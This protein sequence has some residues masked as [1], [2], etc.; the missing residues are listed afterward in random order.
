[1]GPVLLPRAPLAVT[2]A[3]VIVHFLMGALV[4]GTNEFD[5]ALLGIG[6]IL[7]G[8]LVCA[9]AFGLLSG[10]YPDPTTPVTGWRKQ[11]AVA[12][13]VLALV[14]VA[15]RFTVVRSKLA[16]EREGRLSILTLSSQ[17][18]D[19]DTSL[20]LDRLVIAD[21]A[22]I[23]V[24]HGVS[25]EIRTKELVIQGAGKFD[26]SGDT[27]AVGRAASTSPPPPIKFK[28]L[29]QNELLNQCFSTPGGGQ[30]GGEGGQ[31]GRGA[32]IEI[33]A[34]SLTGDPSKLTVDV[35]GGPGG[36]GGPG[37]PMGTCYGLGGRTV[38]RGTRAPGSNGLQGPV[39]HWQLAIR[40]PQGL[41][42]LEPGR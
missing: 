18:F 34:D 24:L 28:T 3:A 1:M 41:T 6:G 16:Y 12:F 15:W 20:Q 31:G 40:G 27:G 4:G 11:R 9:F 25:L 35:S 22:Q 26:G 42:I 38:D 36:R 21:R 14:G 13:C 32:R 39:G 5:A 17:V 37:G 10:P 7:G 30:G 29:D 19:K 33:Q 2:V 8:F 23:R